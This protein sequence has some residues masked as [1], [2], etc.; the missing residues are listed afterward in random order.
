MS[1]LLA[2]V[3]L[4]LLTALAAPDAR[5]LA[6]LSATTAACT[7]FIIPS[8]DCE[9]LA[10]S[11]GP[12]ATSSILRT[13]NEPGGTSGRSASVTVTDFDHF[14]ASAGAGIDYT[15]APPAEYLSQFIERRGVGFARFRDSLTASGGTGSGMIRLQWQIDGSNS[16]VSDA[17]NPQI[18]FDILNEVRLVMNCSRGSTP[19]LS[20]DC[21]SG[22]VSFEDSG[23]EQVLATFDLPMVFGAP[24]FFLVE[25]QLHAITGFRSFSCDDPCI[26]DF[27]G[28]VDA[29]FAS[30]GQLVDVQLFDGLGNELD[31]ALI[32]SESGFRYDLVGQDV[33]EPLALA[34]AAPL[35][36]AAARRRRP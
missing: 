20:A 5:A 3:A 19:T 13:W 35:A 10:P 30:T 9:F 28:N 2:P 23:S 26:V 24:V 33:P 29:D 7:G 15:L 11:E 22:S 14:S 27:H 17:I 25:F 8:I 4:A 32:T 12:G 1:R 16:L 31:P 36:L 34:L 21:G 6:V 18:V